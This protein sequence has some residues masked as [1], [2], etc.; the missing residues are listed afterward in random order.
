[1]TRAIRLNIM[2]WMAR[3]RTIIR[4]FDWAWAALTLHLGRLG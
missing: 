3:L 2:V 1:M 4:G